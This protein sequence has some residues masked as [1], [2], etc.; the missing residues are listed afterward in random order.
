MPFDARPSLTD[1]QPLQDEVIE[2][3]RQ[4]IVAV[5]SIRAWAQE[6]K[7]QSRET[8]ARRRALLAR[9]NLRDGGSSR[10]RATGSDKELRFICVKR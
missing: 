4:R 2:R 6:T 5:A 8:I 7:I 9:L 3:T 1:L 10:K